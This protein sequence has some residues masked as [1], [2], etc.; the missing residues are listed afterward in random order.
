MRNAASTPPGKASAT[1]P[2]RSCTSPLLCDLGSMLEAR[3]LDSPHQVEAEVGLVI[4]SVLSSGH[5]T[6]KRSN[7]VRISSSISNPSWVVPEGNSGDGD[8]ATTLACG[9]LPLI[10]SKRLVDL[11]KRLNRYLGGSAD[12]P[13]TTYAVKHDDKIAGL[14]HSAHDLRDTGRTVSRGRAGDLRPLGHDAT[15]RKI[16]ALLSGAYSF[17]TRSPMDELAS[18]K[19]VGSNRIIHRSAVS[20]PG[21]LS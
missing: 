18:R 4:K 14:W 15:N 3:G 20:D 21:K 8:R 7:T 5:T 2:L 11:E 6:S 9:P 1:A 10:P 12:E 17:S 19:R 13:W 16:S